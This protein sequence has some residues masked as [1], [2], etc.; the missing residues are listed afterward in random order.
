M[1]SMFDNAV[2]L[3]LVGE[4]RDGIR[5]AAQF[6]LLNKVIETLEYHFHGDILERTIQNIGNLVGQIDQNDKQQPGGPNLNLHTV[7]RTDPEVGQP[8][9]AFGCIEGILNLPS[10]STQGSHIGRGEHAPIENIGDATPPLKAARLLGKRMAQPST[11]ASKGHVLPKIV[12]PKMRASHAQL[13]MC[14]TPCRIS[15]RQPATQSL[16]RCGPVG[17]QRSS[18]A[19]CTDI[20]AQT[21]AYRRVKTDEKP[22]F[23]LPFKTAGRAAGFSLSPVDPAG[24]RFL[25]PALRAAVVYCDPIKVLNLLLMN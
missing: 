6:F 5:S 11:L 8:Q 4:K 25:P 21:F 22:A 18:Q 17:R 15:A 9:Q 20:T 23:S 12:A 2:K 1:I 14:F 7:N 3:S 24:F 19:R 13:P 10:L 16:L